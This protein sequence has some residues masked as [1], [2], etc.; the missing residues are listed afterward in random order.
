MNR[1]VR[2]KLWV[3]IFIACAVITGVA[4]GATGGMSYLM[5]QKGR[6]DRGN[7]LRKHM[8]RYLDY[9]KG[10]GTAL[11]AVC[12]VTALDSRIQAF[13]T[14]L[15]EGPPSSR[16]PSSGSA[17]GRM[18]GPAKAAARAQPPAAA[19]GQGNEA[20][21]SQRRAERRRQVT[22]VIDA[23]TASLDP[24]LIVLVDAQGKLAL[25]KGLEPAAFNPAKQ[26][27]ISEV[28]NKMPLSGQIALLDGKVFVVSGAPITTSSGKL[29]GAVV[30][31]IP[32]VRFFADY[33]RQSDSRPKMQHRLVFTD[34]NY[35]V[36]ASVFPKELWPSVGSALRPEARKKAWE[37][38]K[39]VEIIR[40]ADKPY[41]FYSVTVKGYK[42][43]E[44][45]VVGQVFLMRYRKKDLFMAQLMRWIGPAL[46]AIVVASLLMAWV[47]SVWITSP[48]RK[49]IKATDEIVAGHGDLTKRID[50]RS[51]DELGQL[52]KGLNSLFERL[53]AITAQVQQAALQVGTSSTQLCA[54]S[55]QMLEGAKEQAIKTES[56][57]A[58]VT[59]LS[60]S[61]Q[62]VADNAMETT[63][64][65]KRSGD[66][67][68]AAVQ[69]MN[70]IRLSVEDVGKRITKLGESGQRIGKIVEVIRQISEQTSLLALNASIEAAHAGEHGKG[71]AVVADEVSSLAKRVGQSARDIEEL[72]AT[73]THQ[74]AEAVQTMNAAI[75]EVE[76]GTNL[77]K[78]T[79][80]DIQRIVEVFQDTAAAVQEQALASDEIARNM[81]V[82]QRIAQ[83]V[84]ASSEDAVLQGERLSELAH[85]LEASVRG[86]KVAQNAL[87]RGDDVPS[88]RALP[89]KTGG[90]DEA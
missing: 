61:I 30:L 60:S 35:Q 11:E 14:R 41:D 20:I 71:F 15:P 66:E 81:D 5:L 89:P 48:I 3:K 79:F 18:G 76:Q 16:R 43:P 40:L 55:Q 83:E 77:V 23:L 9:Q 87:D 52:A 25:L 26:L 2:M 32:V 69:R 88:S 29:L 21:A 17:V 28:L 42:G 56:S 31:G 64:V 80:G 33:K 78:N 84:L 67:V 39:Q 85:R 7:F 75:Q 36:L 65:A 13:L 51:G 63:Q 68:S 22:S 82:V 59:E 62:Q 50:V 47:L 38:R 49:F 27:F 24:G 57:T 12:R 6:R 58:A 10:L 44:K 73:I 70:Q 37:G 90:V 54:S 1:R 34:K 19:A 8:L 86:F 74:T 72:I 53:E 46:A 45:G 4:V